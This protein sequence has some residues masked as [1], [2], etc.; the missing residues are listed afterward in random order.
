[1]GVMWLF[2]CVYQS[3][4][5]TIVNCCPSVRPS[6]CPFVNS[7]VCTFDINMLD[8]TRKTLQS[9]WLRLW[10]IVYK[11]I[12]IA[13][14]STSVLYEFLDFTFSSFGFK[15][16]R[17]WRITSFMTITRKQFHK[18]AKHFS[19]LFI[20][21]DT[22]FL[23]IFIIFTFTFPIYGF[24]FINKRGIFPFGAFITA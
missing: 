6:V 8:I 16:L 20:A 23:S 5:R 19:E 1:M 12:C 3:K 18:F 21:I 2:V 22:I 13:V 7:S 10:W 4:G 9:I 24:L 11:W 17:K 15:S 14:S